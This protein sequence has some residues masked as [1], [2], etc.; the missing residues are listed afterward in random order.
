M[1]FKFWFTNTLHV[2]N[3]LSE[4]Q[5]FDSHVSAMIV[6]ILGRWS[7]TTTYSDLA[8]GWMTEESWFY[9]RQKQYI[10]IYIYPLF[11]NIQTAYGARKAIRLLDTATVCLYCHRVSLL[12]PGVSTATG[13]HYCH[14]V[15]LLPPCVYPIAVDK[16]INIPAT[17]CPEVKQT[18][19]ECDQWSRP[20]P[21]VRM[22]E[23]TPPFNIWLQWPAAN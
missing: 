2:Q 10:C 8:T 6:T 12:P 19:R 4:R 14:R 7:T 21:R 17:L 20:T 3:V 13:C 23:D 1:F 15:S 22:R 5:W 9:S 11:W 16:Y 18:W